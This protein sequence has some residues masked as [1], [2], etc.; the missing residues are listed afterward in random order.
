MSIFPMARNWEEIKFKFFNIL[1]A[2]KDQEDPSRK[3]ARKK[4]R[5]ARVN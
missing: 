3:E 4:K 5:K 1:N 2:L